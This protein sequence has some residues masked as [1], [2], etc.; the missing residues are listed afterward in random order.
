MLSLQESYR[1]DTPRNWQAAR[2]A[3]IEFAC[4]GGH[5]ALARIW[6]GEG[7][8]MSFTVPKPKNG[9][10]IASILINADRAE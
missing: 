2:K 5:C 1:D 10:H 7:S 4:T 6:T 3:V 9:E 8:T